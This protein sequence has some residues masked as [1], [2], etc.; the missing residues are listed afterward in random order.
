MVPSQ[1]NEEELV[2]QA[3]PCAGLGP[4]P[5]A[6]VLVVDPVGDGDDAIR[7]VSRI[8]PQILPSDELAYSD[9]TRYVTA[10]QPLSRPSGSI[11]EGVMRRAG[12]R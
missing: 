4:I 9:K 10:P 12:S 6:D 1:R 8:G 5:V 3:E 7:R 2:A 11:K